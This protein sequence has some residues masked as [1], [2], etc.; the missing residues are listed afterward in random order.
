MHDDPILELVRLKDES[1]KH[2]GERRVLYVA[3][4]RARRETHVSSSIEAT[5]TFA[6]EFLEE[7]TGKHWGFDENKI[8][9]YPVC[10]SGWLVKNVK[11][12]G[13]GCTNFPACNFRTPPCS[14][15]NEPMKVGLG[16][17]GI[18]VCLKHPEVHLPHCPK[19][20]WGAL[21]LIKIQSGHFLGCH[22]WISTRCK[23]SRSLN[24]VVALPNIIPELED[25]PV[26][27]SLTIGDEN[28][29]GAKWSLEEDLSLVNLYAAGQDIHV[30]ASIFGRTP[31]ALKSRLTNWVEISYPALQEKPVRLAKEFANYSQPFSPAES[32]SL[33]E[34]WLAE[35][36]IT[37]LCNLLERPK[38]VII[39]ALMSVRVLL[40][41]QET[42][43]HIKEYYSKKLV[44][45]ISKKSK[46]SFKVGESAVKR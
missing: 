30:I 19:C 34:N 4:T 13:L 40:P 2:A 35:V 18:Y 23:G 7:E 20:S 14:N 27:D 42:E 31:S 44:G 29:K 25:E 41:N 11:L 5:S 1:F 32:Q 38:H 9:R 12:S 8:S 39:F 10:K 45:K 37:D 21:T 43:T 26:F 28:R 36:K 22:L 17:Q 16:G 6:L 33:I 15:C 24:Q 3:M 46:K